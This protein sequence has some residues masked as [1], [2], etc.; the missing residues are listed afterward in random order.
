MEFQHV[1]WILYVSLSPVDVVIT[2]TPPGAGVFRIKAPFL[3]QGVFSFSGI[4]FQ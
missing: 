3:S 2:G 4:F 1:V